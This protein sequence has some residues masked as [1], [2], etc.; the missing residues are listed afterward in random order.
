MTG[1]ESPQKKVKLK[2]R[3]KQRPVNKR[4]Q[5]EDKLCPSVLHQR[6]DDN[7]VCFV[8]DQNAELDFYSANSLKQQFALD[9]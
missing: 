2:G 8:L 1:D 5:A 7:E 4:I 6:D 9:M 3:N